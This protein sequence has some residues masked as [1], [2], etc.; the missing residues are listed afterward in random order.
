MHML[1]ILWAHVLKYS[2]ILVF[3]P[4]SKPLVSKV[5]VIQPVQVWNCFQAF[6]EVWFEL[7]MDKL[8]DGIATCK[9]SCDRVG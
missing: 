5:Q 9:T 4:Y 6:V 7:I 2:L 3:L 8:T 1:V